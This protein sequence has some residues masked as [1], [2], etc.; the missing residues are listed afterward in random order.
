MRLLAN[1]VG[2]A[3][4]T[5]ALCCESTVAWGQ[6]TGLE[7][8]VRDYDHRYHMLRAEERDGDTR[9]FLVKHFKGSDP[10]VVHADFDGDGQ[11]DYAMLLKSDTSTAAK[12]VVL[13]ATPQPVPACLR[14][15]H[16]WI[17]RG[18]LLVTPSCAVNGCWRGCR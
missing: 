2:L 10:S 5:A 13:L 16:H 14:T 18:G 3:L 11:L 1:L 6:K 17:F 15:G 9:A 8:L 4:L 12:L 7:T